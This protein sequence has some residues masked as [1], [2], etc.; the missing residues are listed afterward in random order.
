MQYGLNFETNED[1]LQ[2]NLG[3]LSYRERSLM[4]HEFLQR[5]PQLVIEYFVLTSMPDNFLKVY[6]RKRTYAAKEAF[7]KTMREVF[8]TEERTTAVIDKVLRYIK[9]TGAFNPSD[10]GKVLG[11]TPKPDEEQQVNDFLNN[12]TN[13]EIQ[14]LFGA[15][16]PSPQP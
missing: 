15:G 16:G 11:R 14:K 5:H 7:R 10:L 1:W 2:D 6:E 4:V 13:A 12:L 9:E 8:L 3:R